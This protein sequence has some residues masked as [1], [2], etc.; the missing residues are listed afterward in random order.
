MKR[1]TIFIVAILLA[2]ELNAQNVGLRLIAENLNSPLQVSEPNDGSGRL[3]VVDQVGVIMIVDSAGNMMN[4]PFL[5]LREEIVEL[6][7]GYDERGLIGLAFHPDYSENGRFYVHYCAPPADTAYDHL[8]VYAEFTVSDTDSNQA[9]ENSERRLLEIDHPQ[10]NHNGGSIQFGHDGYLYLTSGD[11]GNRNDVGFG[12]VEDWY[13]VNPGGNAQNIEANLLGKILRIDVDNGDPYGI[14]ADNPFVDTTGLDEIYA[15]GFRNPYKM[16]FDMGGTNQLFV[17]D[18]GQNL[19]EEISIVE[20]GGNY[21]WNVKEGIHCFNGNDPLNPLPSCP[22]SD[23]YGNTITNPVIEFVN[24]STDTVNGLGVVII[25]GNVYRGTQIADLDGRYL[26]GAFSF[27][28]VIPSGRILVATPDNGDSLW[29]FERLNI[30]DSVHATPGE[31]GQLNHYLLGFGQDQNGE[32]YITVKDSLGPV[33]TSGKVLMLVAAEDPTSVDAG[34]FSPEDYILHQAYP[35]PF[36][37]STTISFEL[38][39][40]SNIELK[41]FNMMGE[42]VANL[43]SGSKPAGKHQ[44]NFEA[45]NL[46]SGMYLFRLRTGNIIKTQKMMLL[47]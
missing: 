18:A 31:Q 35:N 39:A 37:P 33:G 28:P 27:T 32:V 40:Q 25:G 20:M 10:F 22:D 17:S 45:G 46:S 30:I 19:Y 26:F 29:A 5:D 42:E 11:G 38:P 2:Y 23:A 13:D 1:I 7:P 6:R 36:N 14:P 21:G 41:V 16:S 3:F 44:I 8:E 43:F 9:N 12:H 24:S 47:K 34:N 15:Y 4:E